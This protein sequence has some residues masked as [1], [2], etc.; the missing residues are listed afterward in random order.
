MSGTS[1]QWRKGASSLLA[2]SERNM[3]WEHNGSLQTLARNH[4]IRCFEGNSRPMVAL[5]LTAGFVDGR[6]L[7]RDSA[8][9]EEY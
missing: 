9:H 7:S 1:Q 4:V 8:A 3:F 5:G 2:K 6:N